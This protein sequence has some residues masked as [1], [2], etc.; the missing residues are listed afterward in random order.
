MAGTDFDVIIGGYKLKVARHQ[1][2]AYRRRFIRREIQQQLLSQSESPAIQSR[3]D[4]PALYQ[5][6]WSGGARWWK[7]LMVQTN[8]NS[9]YRAN[10]MNLWSEPGKVVPR[11]KFTDVDTTS[12]IRYTKFMVGK[13]SSGNYNIFAIGQ[14]T[15]VNASFY[16]VYVWNSATEQFDQETGYHSGVPS[17]GTSAIDAWAFD[18]SD[19]HF[20]IY[21]SNSIH[22]FDPGS[23]TV[24][25]N[26]LTGVNAHA[27]NSGLFVRNGTLMYKDSISIYEIDKS[28]PSA[29]EIFDDGL[30]LDA[31]VFMGTP[32]ENHNYRFTANTP[33]GI[34][35]VKN[36]ASSHA[37]T[38]AW[39]YRVQKDATGA[40]I[41]NPIAV[42]EDT[43]VPSIYYH[44]GSIVTAAVPDAAAWAN[45][46]AA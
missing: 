17:G 21:K 11:N 46:P 2:G 24:N 41:G 32:I 23:A 13:D 42:L 34:Y 31:T 20:Y 45:A 44:L 40:W 5:S 28:G 6:D 12:T 14:T 1:E 18:P 36:V 25:S 39:I 7:P 10:N 29:T 26:W 38:D 16:D 15:N 3:A 9:Y 33:E 37:H 19:D 30:G 8:L 35:Y 43:L 22:R 4:R 27:D